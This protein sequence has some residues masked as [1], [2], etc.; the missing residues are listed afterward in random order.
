MIC[1]QYNGVVIVPVTIV[2]PQYERE[3]IRVLRAEGAE[4]QHFV[5]TAARATL[6]KWLGKRFEGKKIGRCGRLTDACMVLLMVYRGVCRNRRQ[7][8]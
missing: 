4:V 8:D 2:N 3:I 1:A 7:A 6:Q 5:L